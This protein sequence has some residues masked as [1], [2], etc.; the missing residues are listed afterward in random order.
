MFRAYMKST[1]YT[2]WDFE[3][4]DVFDI[5]WMFEGRVGQNHPDDD[6][7]HPVSLLPN[8]FYEAFDPNY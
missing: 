3:G 4:F 5:R 6:W 7:D 8:T 1:N 2:I